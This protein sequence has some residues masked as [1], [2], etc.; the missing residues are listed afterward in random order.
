MVRARGDRG[1]RRRDLPAL[2]RPRPVGDECRA[3]R[4]AVGLL[5][6]ATFARYEV[7]GEGA[8]AWLDRML[9]NR[10]PREGRHDAVAD[11]ERRRQAD[12]RL[13]RRQRAGDDRFIVFGSGI[14]EQYHLRWFEAH[15]PRAA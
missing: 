13:H 4:D 6:I 9:A 7:S 12:R 8:A 1:A 10:M 3:V 11:A 2:E 15:L 5:E 14:A